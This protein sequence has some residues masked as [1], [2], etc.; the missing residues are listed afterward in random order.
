MAKRPGINATEL[1][2]KALATID[3][4]RGTIIPASIQSVIVRDY[5]ETAKHKPDELLFPSGHRGPVR[6]AIVAWFLGGRASNNFVT[7][8]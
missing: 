4:L 6:G 7:G 2:R 1:C 3:G 5:G 8:T